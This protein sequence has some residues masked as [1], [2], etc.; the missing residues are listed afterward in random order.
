[1]SKL[2]A[3]TVKI[4]TKEAPYTHLYTEIRMSRIQSIN[5]QE[6]VHLGLIAL[7]VP[8]A[9]ISS[10][11]AQ[12]FT[13]FNEC[14]IY[15][16][17]G[18]L[19]CDPK[20]PHCRVMV[21]PKSQ[22]EETLTVIHPND[23]WINRSGV[24]IRARFRKKTKESNHVASLDFIPQLSISNQTTQAVTLLKREACEE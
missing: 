8:F 19:S 1:M 9:I 14:G 12:A 17:F 18:S 21:Y 2:I 16:V 10:S 7:I 3:A 4:F 24:N 15:D 5:I 11:S 20:Q 23:Y 6:I 13:Q 22:S